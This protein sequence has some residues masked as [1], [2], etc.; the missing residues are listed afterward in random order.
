MAKQCKNTISTKE[1]ILEYIK[2]NKF[3]FSLYIALLL[4]VPVKDIL[5][6][7]MIGKFM[8]AIK[9]KSSFTGIATVVACIIV[10]IQISYLVSDYIEV[11]LHPSL[12]AFIRD[13]MVKH[14]FQQKD[15]DYEEVEM[16][17]LIS[18]FLRLPVVLYNYIDQWKAQLIPAIIMIICACVYFIYHDFVSGSIVALFAI[19]FVIVCVITVANCTS[20]GIDR[21]GY[22]NDVVGGVDDVVRNM[23]TVL[24]VDKLED[25]LNNIQEIHN[26]Y[27]ESTE[28]VLTCA[29]V[30]RIILVPFILGF[31]GL[32]IFMNYNKVK[33]NKLESGQF[34]TN[35]IILIILI[36][37]MYNIFNQIKDVIMRRGVIQQS[38]DLFKTCFVAREPY[39]TPSKYNIGIN[40][41]DVSFKYVNQDGENVIFDK[42]N[43]LIHKNE[44]TLLVG[45][46]GSGKST[47]LSLI[48]KYHLPNSGD[49]FLDGIPYS[50]MSSRALRTKIGYIP[51]NPILLNRTVY[52]NI[53]Y[54]NAH[55]T[56]ENVNSIIM[57]FGLDT[58]IKK[59]P[60]GLDTS[61]G[62]YGSKL[63]GGQRMIV[64]ILRTMLMDPE[65]VV[66][67]E[68]TAAIDEST[69]S[70][71]TT[72]LD[73]VMKQKTVVIVTHDPT[74]SKHVDRVIG[75]KD[76]KVIRDTRP[77]SQNHL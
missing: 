3:Y 66:M 54:G 33:A 71:I 59:L 63:S 14:I 26:K 42:L 60:K 64:W 31:A 49:I 50:S 40:V 67:D 74:L 57:K 70:V 45:E 19:I 34:V 24:N 46:I 5:L 55:A 72:L 62:K 35:L 77:V 39:R 18:R 41:Q 22:F 68:P 36:N 61:V 9:N 32:L 23:I 11:K 27:A 28:K 8:T 6:P 56:Q 1:L 65:I 52:E 25:E 69:K 75:F 76:G 53:V 7:H 21:D 12:Q 48:L 51:Q 73:D 15:T 30:P 20:Y 13:M 37:T 47:L 38:M 16:G 58:F 17:Q 29:S 43:L 2:Q 10:I 4:V 44:R